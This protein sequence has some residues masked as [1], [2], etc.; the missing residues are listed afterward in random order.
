[1]IDRAI[2][3]QEVGKHLYD[4]W[5]TDI[6]FEMNRSPDLINDHKAREHYLKT[7]IHHR[8][9]TWKSVE[10]ALRENDGTLE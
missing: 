5:E 1:M 10:S 8:Y 6:R 7:A 9:L 3:I 4:K 2:M